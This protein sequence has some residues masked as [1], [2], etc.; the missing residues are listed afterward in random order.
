MV[1]RRQQQRRIIPRSRR[2]LRLRT[3]HPRNHRYQHAIPV[4]QNIRVDPHPVLKQ[5]IL[6][7]QRPVKRKRSLPLLQHLI[8]HLHLVHTPQHPS[9]AHHILIQD[10]LVPFRKIASR[11][12]HNQRPVP[13]RIRRQRIGAHHI[14]IVIIKQHLRHIQDFL[15]RQ[16]PVSR[17]KSDG[18]LLPPLHQTQSLGQFVL[19]GL[20]RMV[21]IVVGTVSRHILKQTDTHLRT[22]VIH[23]Q[24][25][26]NNLLLQPLVVR[27]PV[28]IHRHN[29]AT[30][31]ILHELLLLL[32]V[33]I[34]RVDQ[35][36]T[37]LIPRNPPELLQHAGRGILQ[38]LHF[39]GERASQKNI[40]PDTAVQTLQQLPGMLRQGI[41]LVIRNIRPQINPPRRHIQQDQQRQDI[42][43]PQTRRIKAPHRQPDKEK[44]DGKKINH[45]A[46]G[47]H[48]PRHRFVMII[49]SQTQ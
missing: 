16:L 30:R 20:D 8:V 10:I 43:R 46:Q 18:L 36:I 45:V 49:D 34:R 32:P 19:Q 25:R 3:V 40:H 27:R 2:I 33:Y 26:K 15:I 41:A 29:P 7:I 48:P 44:N 23:H 12:G 35:C 22:V 38:L 39:C 1:H 5:H 31:H 6:D 21:D 4:Q 13:F 42:H 14:H 28:Q 11:L 17:K 9:S 47:D 37:E 24:P